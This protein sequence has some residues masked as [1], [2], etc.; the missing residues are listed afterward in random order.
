MATCTERPTCPP[1]AERSR[2]P[3][4]LRTR[5]L[6]L[7]LACLVLIASASI[8]RAAEL[9]GRGFAA[10]V[11]NDGA[12]GLQT[13]QGTF[14]YAVDGWFLETSAGLIEHAVAPDI[15]GPLGNPPTISIH[16][17]S[18]SAMDVTLRLRLST[19]G[20]KLYADMV[21]TYADTL[22]LL[23]GGLHVRPSAEAQVLLGPRAITS[24]DT[25][26]NQPQTLY[27]ERVCLSQGPWPEPALLVRGRHE[28]AGGVEWLSANEI[29]FY[30]GQVHETRLRRPG[31]EDLR[32]W[33]GTP[34]GCGDRDSMTIVMQVA[35]DGPC[36]FLDTYPAGRQAAFTIVDDADGER[37]DLL[38]AAYYGCSDTTDA[39]FGTRGICG[40]GLRTTRTVF[41][42][43]R[44]DDVWRR[45]SRSGVEIALHTPSG[46][47]DS[48]RVIRGTLGGH[49]GALRRASLGG[50]QR[51]PREHR[52]SRKSPGARESF[53]RPRCPRGVGDRLCLGRAQPLLWFRRLSRPVRAASHAGP[54]R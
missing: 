45:L 53:L 21:V 9:R 10:I 17:D 16:D 22:T 33:S 11:G 27:T 24:G 52:L 36:V 42:S 6:L 34:R 32:A 26:H 1:G 48:A 54:A 49:G 41:A 5:P 46:G 15:A 25:S 7:V 30:D 50:P 13:P 23:R 31:H 35:H 19:W 44:L 40:H 4:S 43:S 37:A 2:L 29:L 51:Q 47:P 3:G 20:D 12:I 28:G 39:S 38:L 14:L 18:Q 8:G